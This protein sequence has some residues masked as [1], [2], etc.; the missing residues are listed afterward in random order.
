[1]GESP[2]FSGDSRLVTRESEPIIHPRTHSLRGLESPEITALAHVLGS[3][4]DSI[5][6]LLQ[7]PVE[8]SVVARYAFP[9]DI[10]L[11][12]AVVVALSIRGMCAPGLDHD[13][14][15]NQPRYQCAIGICP[16]GGLVDQLFHYD[17]DMAGSERGLLL[18]SKQ[19]PDL[20]VAL[21]VSSLSMEDRDIRI[22][23]RHRGED[24]ASVGTGDRP[25]L[26]IH[27]RKIGPHVIP[28]NPE[29]KPSRPGTQASHHAEVGVFLELERR[30]FSFRCAAERVQGTRAWIPRPG[31]H[32]LPGTTS[33]D[34]LIVNEI[35]GEP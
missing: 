10:E 6:V 15:N 33:G 9:P 1:M 17:D 29:R 14:V 30:T 7:I 25:Y 26:M 8:G 20:G 27:L 31:K 21:G 13:C 22:Q 16:Y 5:D 32:Q 34:H 4:R 35:R 18:H 12:V 2:P 19:S 3:I 23:R 24:L 28:Q 11:V